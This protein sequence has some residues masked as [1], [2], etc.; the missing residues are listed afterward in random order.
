V[1][2]NFS[3]FRI[4]GTLHVDGKVE[5]RRNLVEMDN[6]AKIMRVFNGAVF[7]VQ[8]I[9]LLDRGCEGQQM[10]V[11]SPVRLLASRGV[12]DT[13]VPALLRTSFVT[14]SIALG[15]RRL[16]RTVSALNR[17]GVREATIAWE[18]RSGACAIRAKL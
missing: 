5:A 16:A 17:F 11:I 13:I 10:N 15:P 14:G 4:I 6:A 18:A 9:I 2:A 12:R 1:R 8:T 3:E 7:A